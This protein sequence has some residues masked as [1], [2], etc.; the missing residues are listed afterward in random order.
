MNG[1]NEQLD[2]IEQLLRDGNRLRE[3]ALD[4]QQ[5]AIATQRESLEIQKSLVGETRA[6]IERASKVNEGALELQKR[7]RKIVTFL[8]PVVVLLILY[9]SYL[10]FFPRHS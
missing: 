1:A 9:V 4:L 5:Q 7:A 8:L 6:N 2:R 10:I 3:R